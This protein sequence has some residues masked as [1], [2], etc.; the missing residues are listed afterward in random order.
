MPYDPNQRGP[1]PVGVT[2]RPLRDATRDRVLPTELWYPAHEKHAGDDLS[3]ETQDHYSALP[4]IMAG[5]Q[6]AVRDAAVAP[7]HR[8][9]VV[10][11]HGFGSQ[12]LQSTFLC[13][14]LAS[15]GYVVAAP[16]HVGNT[17]GEMVRGV[18]SS[19]SGGGPPPDLFG[20]M[21]SV[22][23]DRVRDARFLIDA[24]ANRGLDNVTLD[25]SQVAVSG[26]SFGGWTALM[27]GQQDERVAAVLPL[28]P[29]GG[30][31]RGPAK[32]LHDAIFAKPWRTTATLFIVAERDSVLPLEGMRRLFARSGGPK[33]MVNILNADHM[34]FCDRPETV[35]E[36]FRSI[37]Q[38]A[39]AMTGD[40][41]MAPMAELCSGK[42]SLQL[43]RGLGLAHL[44]ATLGNDSAAAAWLDGQVV[45]FASRAGV[46][47]EVS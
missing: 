34:H 5:A 41:R 44:D 21:A 18:M 26:H 25:T 22:A 11:S 16:D 31:V 24:L 42:A 46:D 29:A 12:R 35:H 9:L 40:R 20:D 36:L 2:H 37:P 30:A 14:H 19:M 33:R 1:H 47:I 27:A 4:G 3:R 6:E 38:V 23:R 45:S 39:R 13:T 8:R 28:A 15:H 32:G 10:F 43:V 7:G 17:L